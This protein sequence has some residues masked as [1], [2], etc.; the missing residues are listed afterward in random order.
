MTDTAS[1]PETT[2]AP[3]TATTAGGVRQ[4]WSAAL[5]ALGSNTNRLLMAGLMLIAFSAWLYAR[6]YTGVRHDGL[7]Y[8]AQSLMRRW[9]EIYGSDFFFAHGSQDR[10]SIFSNIFSGL[11]NHVG[12]VGLVPVLLLLCQCA[13]AV[14]LVVLLCRL[15]PVPLAALGLMLAAA[16]PFYGGFAMFA[17]GEPF[18]TAR[19][20]AEPLVLSALIAWYTGRVRWAVP[21]FALAALMHPLI[22]L[23]GIG[24]ALVMQAERTPRLWWL[25]LTVPLLL[26]LAVAGVPGLEFLV[27]RFDD[28]WWA[29]LGPNAAVFP[30]Q[31]AMRDWAD[32]MFDLAVLAACSRLASPP[33]AAL[34]RAALLVAALGVCAATWGGD[35]FR[36][37]LVSQAQLWRAQWV[38]HALACGLF[39]WL[40]WRLRDRGPYAWLG[41]ALIFAGIAFRAQDNAL[42][43]PLLGALALWRAY[44]GPVKMTRAFG[45]FASAAVVFLIVAAAANDLY[46]SPTLG[47]ARGDESELGYFQRLFESPGVAVVMLGMGCALALQL[48]R[49]A[50]V[51][52]ALSVV[53]ALGTWDRRSEWSKYVESQIDTPSH[54]DAII[55]P[56][57]Q[58]YWPQ[59]L[60][61]PWLLI[62]RASYFNLPQGSGLIFQRGTAMDYQFRREVV[63]VFETQ[64]ELCRRVGTLIG[65]CTISA[66][67]LRDLCTHRGGPDFVVTPRAMAG[68][69]RDHWVIPLADASTREYFLYEC[70][71]I[72]A[73]AR[74]APGLGKPS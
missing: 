73:S 36:L 39:P 44:R 43:A 38:G 7:L 15:V 54:W 17:F 11:A 12:W 61:A 55:P 20:M 5:A 63:D 30:Q 14:A 29:A 24:I 49:S 51:V 25:A 13:F 56:R 72:A 45:L 42:F 3:P 18:L 19:S 64:S 28:V 41:L 6:P 57:A 59:D 22:A 21:L 35:V 23:P 32:L 74:A 67:A 70:A 46:L 34:A 68:P 50:L 60:Q 37:V 53:V 9:P 10:Y 71:V 27:A 48:P 66:E 26:G 69:P 58:V 52:G 2:S 65:T 47:V 1:S 62:K 8:L 40:V 31:W 4:S 33:V 16:S